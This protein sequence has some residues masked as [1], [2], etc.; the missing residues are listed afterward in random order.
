MTFNSSPYLLHTDTKG[1]RWKQ[2]PE[3]EVREHPVPLYANMLSTGPPADSQLAFLPCKNMAVTLVPGVALLTCMLKCSA[4]KGFVNYLFVTTQPFPKPFRQLRKQ[5]IVRSNSTTF[6]S[7]QG[8]MHLKCF[9][10]SPPIWLS[11]KI[12]II[13]TFIMEI[14]N[15]QIPSCRRCRACC[16]SLG[17]EGSPHHDRAWAPTWQLPRGEGGWS[18]GPEHW[19]LSI[20]Y[21]FPGKVDIICSTGAAPEAPSNIFIITLSSASTSW[22]ESTWPLHTCA[23]YWHDR[24]KNVIICRC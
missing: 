20:S 11:Q 21:N 16:F 4:L 9:L 19:V 15:H 14:Q 10:A 6:T 7:C 23:T 22:A 12:H 17:H 18:Q 2:C 8:W 1:K 5:H 24:V 13:L 3:V